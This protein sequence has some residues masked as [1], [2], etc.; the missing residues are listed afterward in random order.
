MKHI[1][2]YVLCASTAIVAA[3]GGRVAP[4]PFDLRGIERGRTLAA[5]EKFLDEAPVTVTASRSPRSAGGPHDFFSEGDY[6]WPDPKKKDGL[7]YIR[8]DGE[9]NP[10]IRGGAASDDSRQGQ[11]VDAVSNLALAFYFT[12][13]E[14]Y[15]AHAAQLLRVWYVDPATRMNP[16]L[17][18]GQAIPGITEGR[19][20]GIIDTVCLLA[21]PD[22]ITLLSASKSLTAEDLAGLKKWY[23]DYLE[24]L[25]TSKNGKAEAA[26]E[27]NHGTWY[28]AQVIT[29]ALF[30]G[31]PDVAK[32]T[33]ETARTKRIARQ[34]EPDGRQPLELA[35]TK[36]FGYSSMNLRGMLTLAWL[37]QREG[38]DLTGYTAPG[39]GSI[40]KAV[41]YLLQYADPAKK[42]PNK[43][44]HGYKP[45]SLY[46]IALQAGVIY[47]DDALLQ[48]AGKLCDASQRTDTIRL[49]LNR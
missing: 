45:E 38:V 24:W 1:V 9:V 35:R 46:P 29:F 16:N 37:G 4:P 27:N 12:G 25:L 36:S 31:R 39:G 28:D 43:Q 17:N 40:R 26:A 30:T 47:K 23:A 7:P 34:I 42:W 41:D 48:L 21:I 18:F 13:D 20:I 6:W 5:A 2:L 22:S 3:G 10:E 14:Q 44:I 8:R 19:G 33:L 15:A 11:M 49:K 32:K